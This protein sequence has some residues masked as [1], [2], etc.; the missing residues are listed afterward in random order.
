MTVHV[1]AAIVL[2]R[3]CQLQKNT[4]SSLHDSSLQSLRSTVAHI[5]KSNNFPE[6]LTEQQRRPPLPP[7]DETYRQ[8]KS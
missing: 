7:Q 6:T 5:F 1:E 4:P 8:G 2:R 3:C